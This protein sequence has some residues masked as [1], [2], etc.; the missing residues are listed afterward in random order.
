MGRRCLVGKSCGMLLFVCLIPL[1]YCCTG[2]T[3]QEKLLREALK[4]HKNSDYEKALELY[5]ALITPTS[6]DRLKDLTA[7]QRKYKVDCPK[8]PLVLTNIGA[9]HEKMGEREK[10]MHSYSEAIRVDRK[11]TQA[12]LNRAFLLVKAG[13][14][15]SAVSDFSDALSIEPQNFDAL[16]NRAALR[17][18]LG[19][20]EDALDDYTKAIAADDG[21]RRASVYYQ[22]ARL[23]ESMGNK[24]R[25][26]GDYSS[27]IERDKKNAGY[28][29]S[30]AL[31]KLS[32]GRELEAKEDLSAALNLSPN[33]CESLFERAK[34]YLKLGQFADAISD[35]DAAIAIDSKVSK[36]WRERARV[37]IFSSNGKKL[38]QEGV[39]DL[40]RAI[41]LDPNDT[42]A[43]LLRAKEMKK[44]G[45]SRAAVRDY[46]KV[47]GYRPRNFEVVYS[48]ASLYT[49][50]GDYKS[51]IIYLSDAIELRPQDPGLYVKRGEAKQKVKDYKGAL[52]DFDAAGRLEGGAG[53]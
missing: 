19:K 25:A 5:R 39:A 18:S 40:G 35:L 30:R 42:E 1:L 13:E 24:L 29:H 34:L 46:L 3:E 26:L 38:S 17:Q 31:L 53:E 8:L 14:I 27:A 6:V 16:Y 7:E 21:K 36:Y 10:A 32:M 2:E 28:Y 52:E 33:A 9:V 22:R 37:K 41:S 45:K 50:I 48:L 20:L 44:A 11:F 4:A 15:N 51:A 43:Y 47:L 12:F 23:N 49:E